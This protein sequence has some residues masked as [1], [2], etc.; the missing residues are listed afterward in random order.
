MRALRIV[1]LLG[2]LLAT[3]LV[4]AF[5]WLA[6]GVHLAGV[7]QRLA[8]GAIV[9]SLAIGLWGTLRGRLVVPLGLA[10]AGVALIS[11]WWSFLPAQQDRD[12][13]PEYARHLIATVDGDTVTL[14]NVRNFRWRD[15]ETA[16]E[17]WET[18]N[19]DASAVTSVDVFTSVWG[20]PNIAHV[21]V[22]FGFADG[23]HIA[24]SAETRRRV[25]QVYST[26]GG[27]VREFELTLIAADERDLIWLRTDLRGERVSLFPLTLTPEARRRLFL[28]FAEFADQLERQPQ[29]YNTL[30]DNCTTVPLRIVRGLNAQI[31]LDWRVLASGRLPAYLHD[32]GVLRPDLGIAEVE[33]QAVL[34]VFGPWP[35]DGLAYSQA[36]RSVWQP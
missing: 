32:L 33:A 35:E 8:Q 29:W 9:L 10:V 4:L 34:P 12:W 2:C 13:A 5:L 19:F 30:L 3:I 36:I 26:F 25:G 20:N 23:Q 31:P 24:F 28:A 14:E 7:A 6:V 15:I 16:E 27:F 21:M 1:L 18:R 22:S 11:V 17:V